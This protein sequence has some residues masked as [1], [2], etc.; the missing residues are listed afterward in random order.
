MPS[1]EEQIVGFS[2]ASFDESVTV[3]GT[4]SHRVGEQVAKTCEVKVANGALCV[5]LC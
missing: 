2:W 3:C 5:A 4:M 1:S